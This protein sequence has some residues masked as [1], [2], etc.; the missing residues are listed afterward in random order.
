MK[1]T[2]FAILVAAAL[3]G[4]R[5]ERVRIAGKFLG[6]APQTVYLEQ[7]N[8]SGQSLVD[9]VALAPDGSYR[10]ELANVPATP[11]MYNVVYNNERIPLLVKGGESLTVGSL[12][13]VLVNYTVSGSA[14]S[15][16]LRKFNRD[17]IAGVQALN[18]IMDEYADA[19]DERERK[20]IARRYNAQY[21]SV[22]RGQISFIVEHKE[23]IAAVYAL[24]QRLPGEQY[25]AGAE[26]DIIYFRTV[27]DAVAATYPESP[28]MVTLR[29]DV[30]RMEARASLLS[31][32]QERTYPDLEAADMYGNPVRLSSLEGNVILVDFWSAE[33]GNSN[34]LNADLKEI[35]EEYHGR[36]FRVYQVA[37]DT[38]KSIWIKAVQEQRLP[39]VSVCD[40]RGEASPLPGTY[41]VR[42]LPSNF[43]IGRD[44]T[45]IGRDLYSTALER[46]LAE[47]LK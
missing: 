20:E 17:Y 22:K 13:S 26:S 12:G 28:Y 8:L 27:A 2:L 40:F 41:N 5:S 33:A 25:L 36:G 18:A 19:S 46:R 9:S 34:A 23:S 24:Y 21:R 43:L 45:I 37:V 32:I 1:K 44:G 39:W 14:E 30:A 7:M 11:T 42:K 35:Y 3:C 31:S 16:L 15:E 29:N 47:L 10:F 38:S 6:L 4:C